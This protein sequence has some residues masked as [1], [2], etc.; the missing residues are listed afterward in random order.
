MGRVKVIAFVALLASNA[1]ADDRTELHLR[2]WITPT[3]DAHDPIL[4]DG[5]EGSIDV[6]A[7]GTFTQFATSLVVSET[8]AI[9]H[10]FTSSPR[11]AFSVEAVETIDVVIDSTTP[12]FGLLAV[13]LRRLG[14]QR[15]GGIRA[16]NFERFSA[17]LALVSR[18]ATLATG[19]GVELGGGTLSFCGSGLDMHVDGYFFGRPDAPGV[20]A[21]ITVSLGYIY[22]PRVG[23]H[24]SEMAAEPT[25]VPPAPSAPVTPKGPPCVEREH[26]E[27]ALATQ[28]RRSVAACNAARD[29]TSRVDECNREWSA[30]LALRSKLDA[31][32]A[33]EDPDAH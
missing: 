19:V 17:G 7:G 24:R 23:A 33:G 9:G 11:Q 10:Y 2:P 13:G 3:T 26:I 15:L 18:G 22:S 1:S 21:M 28:R 25:P 30:S 5:V 29:D 32:L 8:G 14:R 12:Q 16:L 27:A 4:A 20:D 31:C 6:S